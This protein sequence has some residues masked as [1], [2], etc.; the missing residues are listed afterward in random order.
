MDE[1][2]A[3]LIERCQG[4]DQDAFGGIVRKYAGAASGAAYL[5]LGCR[6]EAL[7]ASQEAFVRAWRHIRR[8]QP[9]TRFYPWY[10]RI[11]RNVCISRLRSR[12]RRRTVA[13]AADP[14]ARSD[15]DPEILVER[16][17]RERRVWQAIFAL[18]LAHREII[19][20]AHFQGLSYKEMAEA[21]GIPIGTVMSRLHAARRALRTKLA[22]EES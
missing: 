19:S 8:F 11:L 18:P 17:E 21:L 20:L 22:G 12:S 2:E 5:M 10:A 13:L 6:E 7:D 15:A 4:G 3:A 14:P 9:G 1:T 16:S